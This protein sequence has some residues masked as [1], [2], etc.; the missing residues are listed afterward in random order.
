MRKSESHRS[1]RPVQAPGP[2]RV[3]CLRRQYTVIGAGDLASSNLGAGLGFHT[4]GSTARLGFKASIVGWCFPRSSRWLALGARSRRARPAPGRGTFNRMLSSRSHACGLCCSLSFCQGLDLH[5]RLVQFRIERINL[6]T[7]PDVRTRIGQQPF[8]GVEMPL[9]A[10]DGCQADQGVG[11]FCAAKSERGP[12]GIR[13]SREARLP[14]APGSEWL[15]GAFS[16]PRATS[17]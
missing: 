9:I 11:D 4:L 5:V 1:R 3:L 17:P 8:R 7:D 10:L 13:F 16:P 2:V 12:P 15:L 14:A 6:Q